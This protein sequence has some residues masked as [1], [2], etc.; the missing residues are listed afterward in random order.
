MTQCYRPRR[1]AARWLEGAP[2]FVLDCFDHPK[3]A[4]R[5]T[6][7]FGGSLLDSDMLKNRRVHCLSM[8]NQPMHP[9]GVSYWAE[10]ESSWRPSHYRVR[11]LDLPQHIREHVIA[12]ATPE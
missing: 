12:R 8:S 11:W 1:A 5:Y 3:M 7:L 6:V 4:D 10:A 2:E 9:Q